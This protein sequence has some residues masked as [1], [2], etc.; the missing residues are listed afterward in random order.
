MALLLS[1]QYQEKI[2]SVVTINAAIKVKDIRINIASAVSNLNDLLNKIHLDGLLKNFIETKPQ[3]PEFNYNKNYI[4]AIGE[5]SSLMEKCRKNL[6]NINIPTLIVQN[7]EDPVINHKSAEIIHNEIISQAKEILKPKLTK[8]LEKKHVITHVYQP[9]FDD[10]LDFIN[11][12]S[13]WT[14]SQR[15][16]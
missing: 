9:Y 3:N 15:G 1:S 11:T 5:L 2:K 12:Q 8:D 7:P 16:F 6:C 14:S 13:S 4:H 10:I